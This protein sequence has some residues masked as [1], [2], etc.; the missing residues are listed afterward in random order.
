MARMSARYSGVCRKTGTRINPGDTIDYDRRTR[1]TVLVMRAN[2]A[3]V[4]LAQSIDPDLDPESAAE[5]GRYL[6]Q[7]MARGVSTIWNSGGHEFY[8]NR[9][10]R[11][12]DAPCCGCCNI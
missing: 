3:D 7:S 6:R 2:S 4:S 12:E 11:C 1:S 5:A 9:A 8:R 10:G